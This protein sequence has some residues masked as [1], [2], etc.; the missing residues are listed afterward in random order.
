M[1]VFWLAVGLVILYVVVVNVLGGVSTW[2]V[3]RRNDA[4]E[5]RNE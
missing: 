3:I 1:R 4:K 5:R 2:M